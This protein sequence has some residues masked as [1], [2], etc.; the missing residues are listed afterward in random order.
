MRAL[1]GDFEAA[2]GEAASVD[3]A[4]TSAKAERQLRAQAQRMHALT[5]QA[6]SALGMEL[7]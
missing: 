6:A 4:K 1:H 7:A 3:R 5:A 2:V